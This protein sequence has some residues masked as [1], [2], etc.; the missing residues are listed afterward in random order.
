MHIVCHELGYGRGKA[1]CNCSIT[2]YHV[3]IVVVWTILSPAH[4]H[5]RFYG[6]RGLPWPT[7]HG[8]HRFGLRCW[9]VIIVLDA[10]GGQ[11]E[12][13]MFNLLPVESS[14]IGVEHGQGG[15]LVG[16]VA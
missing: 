8:N 1:A 9:G 5:H 4:G 3:G 15:R 14:C 7:L 11:G 10:I 12:V 2:V 16:I 6:L 13:E